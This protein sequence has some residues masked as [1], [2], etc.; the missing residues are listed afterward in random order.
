MRVPK[1]KAE[2]A[3]ES[4]GVARDSKLYLIGKILGKDIRVQ[5]S[6]GQ[7]SVYVNNHLFKEINLIHSI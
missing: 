3:D 2:E 1:N 4:I 5:E 7:F 6:G